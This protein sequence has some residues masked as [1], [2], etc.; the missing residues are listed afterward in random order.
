M[1]EIVCACERVLCVHLSLYECVC[2]YVCVRIGVYE[3]VCAC[4]HV[5]VFVWVYMSVCVCVCVRECA[6]V[7]ACERVCVTVLCVHVFVT[8]EEINVYN[9]TGMTGIAR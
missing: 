3:C 4:V 5:C 7:C 8:Y 1:R 2:A 9:D 6:Y